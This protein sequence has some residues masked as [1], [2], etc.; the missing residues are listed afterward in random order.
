MRISFTQNPKMIWKRI[1]GTSAPW[2]IYKYT[3][4]VAYCV[5]AYVSHS[6]AEKSLKSL[7]Q[8]RYLLNKEYIQAVIRMLEV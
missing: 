4:S 6:R 5:L 2:N 7:Q 3:H 8:Y 1:D